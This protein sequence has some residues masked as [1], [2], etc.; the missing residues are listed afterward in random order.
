MK[1]PL[2]I[3][4]AGSAMEA[5]RQRFGDFEDW[6]AAGF[7]LPAEQIRLVLVEEGEKLPRPEECGGVVITGSHAMV[8]DKLPWSVALTQW[9]PALVTMR[10]PLLG[11]CYGHQLLAAA[12]G[13]R[14]DYHPQGPEI[15]TV[16]VELL[17]AA[18]D[19]PLFAGL[20]ST[21]PAHAFHS[22]SVLSLPPGATLLARNHFEPRHGFRIGECAWGVQF[23]PEYTQAVMA[24]E[25]A[26]DSEQL[27]A[28]GLTPSALLATV[29]ECPEAH[30]LLA[31]F[32][33]LAS[34]TA[35]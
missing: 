10:I 29:R 27:I 5:V 19:D 34:A 11:V 15:G 21:F 6:L 12:M 22:Q 1:R 30:S 28:D 33:R 31:R 32:A 17:P 4:K 20:P 3:L 8:T 23:H 24:A 35:C 13:G 9:L 14:V 18:A 2:V 26:A 16:A 25:I 7:G